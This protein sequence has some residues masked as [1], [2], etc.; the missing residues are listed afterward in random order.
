ML[1]RV[2]AA[3]GAGVAS[4]RSRNSVTPDFSAAS[5]SR[6]LAV[7]VSKGTFPQHSTTNTPSPEQAAASAAVR[8]NILLSGNSAKIV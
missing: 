2:V 6:R 4:I 1:Q 3:L 7:R 8:N 5:A